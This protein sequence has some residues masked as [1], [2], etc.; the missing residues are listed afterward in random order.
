[1]PRQKTRSMILRLKPAPDAALDAVAK[2]LGLNRT[3]A[4]RFLVLEKARAMGLTLP[5]E[6]DDQ[7]EPPVA[8][9]QSKRGTRR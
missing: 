4:I 9:A 7:D 6:S 5:D 3:S 1:M 2:Q 8:P